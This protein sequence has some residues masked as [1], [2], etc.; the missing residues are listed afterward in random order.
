ML[1]LTIKKGGRV[2]IGKDALTLLDVD[3]GHIIIYFKG[4]HKLAMHRVYNL[5]GCLFCYNKKKGKAANLAI[6]SREEIHRE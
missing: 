5:G 1:V 2:K 3:T 6:S 4:Y